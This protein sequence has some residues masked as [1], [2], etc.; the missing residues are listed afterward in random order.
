MKLSEIENN[1]IFKEIDLNYGGEQTSDSVPMHC[2][3]ECTIVCNKGLS[4]AQ[5]EHYLHL[6]FSGVDATIKIDIDTKYFHNIPF[7]TMD[8][9]LVLV[10]IYNIWG[11][12][13]RLL[14]SIIK[15]IFNNEKGYI[16]DKDVKEEKGIAYVLKYLISKKIDE[17]S[18]EGRVLIKKGDLFELVL[19]A[20]MAGAKGD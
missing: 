11:V 7:N 4:Q 14:R 20:Y 13:T 1:I 2:S 12:N 6:I 8:T 16:L 10:N 3:L 19:D 18:I 17:K 9:L 15:D 5:V